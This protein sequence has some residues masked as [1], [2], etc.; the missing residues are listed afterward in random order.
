MNL[1]DK[2][3][4]MNTEL[5]TEIG[6]T[7]PQ[8]R[9]Y[10]GLMKNG[11]ITPPQLATKIGESRTNAYAI[12]DKLVSLGLAKKSEKNKKNIY[13]V[14][15][16]IALERLA[17]KHR[18]KILEKEKQVKSIMPTL[19][20]YFYTFSE[21]PGV[22]FFQ[23]VDGIKEIYSDTIRTG[24]DITLIHSLADRELMSL[25][26]YLEHSKKRAKAGIKTDIISPSKQ[27]AFA[28]EVNSA[29]GITRHV[30]NSMSYTAPVEISVYGDKVAMIS[31]D[32][33]AMGTIIDSPQIAEAI[34]QLLQIVQEHAT[35]V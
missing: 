1:F 21:Q 9:A 31:F 32:K 27:P 35:V 20:N 3:E 22:R 13:I 25:D 33:E 7:E 11:S 6:L 8:A 4:V 26:Y 17:I 2:I 34:K 29:L 24:K 28:P 14:E 5:L 23:G 18:N 19:L 16:P 15:N 10:I 12:L 30:I